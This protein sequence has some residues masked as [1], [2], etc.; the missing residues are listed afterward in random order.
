M[1][2]N[3][4]RSSPQ[5]TPDS[6]RQKLHMDKAFYELHTKKY[7]GRQDINGLEYAGTVENFGSEMLLESRKMRMLRPPLSEVSEPSQN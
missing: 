7:F 6:L 2:E 1:S 5:M 4:F 3:T